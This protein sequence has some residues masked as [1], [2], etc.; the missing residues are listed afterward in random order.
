MTSE[1]E[2]TVHVIDTASNREIARAY[3]TLE[4]AAGVA[5]MD[6]VQHTFMQTITLGEDKLR[7]MGVGQA[8]TSRRA[9][10]SPVANACGKQV[11]GSTGW[12]GH[13]MILDPGEEHH[14]RLRPRRQ[15]ARV[16]SPSLPTA[17]DL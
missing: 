13:V 9:Y 15:H 10:R 3:V 8:S 6:A 4:T 5:V 12:Q 2:G 14:H 16:D 1:N 11:Y 17:D 7:P